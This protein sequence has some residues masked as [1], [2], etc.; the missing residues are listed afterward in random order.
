MS[1]TSTVLRQLS[2]IAVFLAVLAGLGYLVDTAL[3]IFGIQPAAL[4]FMLSVVD[5]IALFFGMVLA[6]GGFVMWAASGLK[7]ETGLALLIGGFCISMLPQ[8]L[9]GGFAATCIP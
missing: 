7:S 4:C 3:P 9:G 1:T 5:R 8:I 2:N 6:C